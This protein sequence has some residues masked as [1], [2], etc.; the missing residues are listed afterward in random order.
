MFWLVLCAIMGAQH[1][2]LHICVHAAARVLPARAAMAARGVSREC[3]IPCLTGEYKKITGIWVVRSMSSE[4]RG[5]QAQ[6]RDVRWV[7]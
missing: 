7:G 1:F 4:A 2:N 3:E 6:E 5:A